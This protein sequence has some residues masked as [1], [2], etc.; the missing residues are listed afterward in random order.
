MAIYYVMG[1]F[2][3][4]PE[5][6]DYRLLL[7]KSMLLWYYEVFDKWS[8]ATCHDNEQW[9]DRHDIS[10]ILL[11]VA[12]STIAPWHQYWFLTSVQLMTKQ[13]VFDH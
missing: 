12:L 13:Y 7:K 2:L 11:K 4:N 1:Y 8:N 6:C 5:K 3:V 10:E 9:N